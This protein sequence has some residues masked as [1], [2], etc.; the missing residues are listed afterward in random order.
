MLIRNYIDRVKVI[1]GK[2]FGRYYPHH[3]YWIDIRRII[4]SPEFK[5]QRIGQH[6]WERKLK[7]FLRTGQFQ[8]QILLDMDFTL[9]DGYSTYLIARKFHVGKVPVQFVPGFTKGGAA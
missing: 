3:E 7:F 5:A 2:W 4:I 9:V 8:S 6:K 1:V